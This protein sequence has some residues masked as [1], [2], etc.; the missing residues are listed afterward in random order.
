[1]CLSCGCQRPN[2]SHGD[3]R[4]LTLDDLRQAGEAIGGSWLDALMNL[5]KTIPTLFQPHHDDDATQ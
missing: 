3:K 4:N 5:L 1:M 2:D